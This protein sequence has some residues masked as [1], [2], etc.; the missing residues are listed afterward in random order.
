MK[1]ITHFDKADAWRAWCTLVLTASVTACGGGGDDEP[2]PVTLPANNGLPADTVAAYTAPAPGTDQKT[3]HLANA[4]ANAGNSKLFVEV[5]RP[6]YCFGVE[7]GGFP[8]GYTDRTPVPATKIFD[9]VWFIGQNWIGQL[10]FKA[11][12]GVFLLDTLNDTASVKAFTEPQL[13]AAGLDPHTLFAAMPLHGHPDHYGGAQ[14]LQSTYGIPIYFSS[15]D[16]SA[17]PADRSFT[18]TKITSE[19]LEPQ[20]YK[21]GDIDMT[22]MSTPGHTAGGLSTIL[23]VTH[24]GTPHKIALWGGPGMAAPGY[25]P[26]FESA[27]RFYEQA[28]KEGADGII[29]THPFYDGTQGHLDN[30]RANG[31]S[32]DNPFVLGKDLTLRT[33]TVLR[34]CSAARVAQLDST[35]VLPQ[36]LYTTTQ[37]S[38]TWIK[39]QTLKNLSASA[40]VKTPYGGVSGATVTFTFSGGDVCSAVSDASGLASCTTTSTAMRQDSVT[41]S[42]AGTENT[43]IRNLPSQ[44]TSPITAF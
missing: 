12:Q 7:V 40:R 44:G 11:N 4:T 35:V 41:A 19:N 3:L 33:L 8:A 9:N 16:L 24:N 15:A 39:N 30:I 14:Y 31:L 26:Y 43:A 2:Q 5:I 37:V 32:K 13:L 6:M 27:Q 25:W 42:F 36:W 18:A 28:A 10:A 34:N 20:P 29:S 17:V 1:T 22:I 38:G 23:H 21:F